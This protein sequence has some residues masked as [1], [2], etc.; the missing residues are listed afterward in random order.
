MSP[1]YNKL[2]TSKISDYFPFKCWRFNTE[3]HPVIQSKQKCASSTAKTKFSTQ[4]LQML[5]GLTNSLQCNEREAVRIALYEA[6]RSSSD[7]YKSVISASSVATDK[8]HRG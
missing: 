1:K 8:A 6:S 5:V 7:A 3:K 4:E 2:S